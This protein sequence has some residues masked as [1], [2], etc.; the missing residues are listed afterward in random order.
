MVT[1]VP[2][3]ISINCFV[4]YRQVDSD[5]GTTKTVRYRQ[6]SAIAVSE[7]CR[8]QSVLSDITISLSQRVSAVDRYYFI[9]I[10]LM[11]RA[12]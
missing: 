5:T 2:L 3:S 6:V 11:L 12:L 10:T 7:F 1:E 4:R 9:T 8:D